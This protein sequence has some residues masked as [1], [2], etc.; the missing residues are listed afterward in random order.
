VAKIANAFAMVGVVVMDVTALT[1]QSASAQTPIQLP[2]IDVIGTTPLS[3]APGAGGPRDITGID[4]DKAPR[5][6][7]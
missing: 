6:R 5:H 2:P 1:V 7:S 4:R 3:T